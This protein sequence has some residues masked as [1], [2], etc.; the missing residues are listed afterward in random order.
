MERFT[1]NHVRVLA[2]DGE[3]FELGSSPE[4]ETVL[5]APMQL[6]FR[7]IGTSVERGASFGRAQRTEQSCGLHA[8]F[9][10]VITALGERSVQCRRVSTE[11]E[12][13]LDHD[14]YQRY[15]KVGI[16]R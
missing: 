14:D 10:M 8:P 3:N 1:K 16:P 4:L 13:L 2:L 12:E 9:A 5:G 15:V 7:A 11:H 6:Q